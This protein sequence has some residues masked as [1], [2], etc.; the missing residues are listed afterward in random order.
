MDPSKRVLLPQDVSPQV[1]HLDLDVFLETHSF[2]G[3]LAIDVTV[4]KPEVTSVTLHSKELSIEQASFVGAD[5]G[6]E[7]KAEEI[8][9]NLK[10]TTVA[11]VFGSALPVGGG[12]LR[13]KFRGCL[14]DQMAGFYRSKYTAL[15]GEKRIMASTQFEALDARRCFPC[16]DEPAAKAQFDVTLTVPSD[17]QAFSNMPE[18]RSVELPGGRRRITFERTPTRTHRT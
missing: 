16:W 7:I 12:Q 11:V 5:A 4:N 18:T 14:N 3:N 1:Y 15:N 2:D 9:F 10:L 6:A 13:L 17:R 8:N